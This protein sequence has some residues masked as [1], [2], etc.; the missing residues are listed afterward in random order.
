[1]SLQITDLHKSFDG[2]ARLL[3]PALG[4]APEGMAPESALLC[5]RPERLQ[6]QAS[7]QGAGRV[8]GSTFLGSIQRVQLRWNDLDLLAEYSSAST[9]ETG[10]NVDISVSAQDC[11]WV[12]A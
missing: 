2:Q 9:W 4:D 11:A 1:M 10:Q 8:T 5:I 3:Q 7:A 6:L 12:H